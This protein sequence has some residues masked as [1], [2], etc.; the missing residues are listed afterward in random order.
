MEEQNT[1]LSNKQL[2]AAIEISQ[3]IYDNKLEGASNYRNPINNDAY[4]NIIKP[5]R[6]SYKNAYGGAPDIILKRALSSYIKEKALSDKF[7]SRAFHYFGQRR[8]NSHVWAC[9]TRVGKD[10]ALPASHDCQLYVLVGRFG[11]RFGFCYGFRV[12]NNSPVVNKVKSDIEIQKIIRDTLNKNPNLKIYS[13]VETGK[14]PTQE[15]EINNLSNW[16]FWDSKTQII[17]SYD[18]DSIP[19]NIWD[20]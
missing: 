13:Q 3:L 19:I 1:H 5:Q 14:S 11:I 20:G 4:N 6:E 8:I 7:E 10:Q 9:I 2:S 15:H 16:D 12:K 18:K 17:Q